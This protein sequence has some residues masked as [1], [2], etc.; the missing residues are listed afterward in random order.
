MKDQNTS[1]VGL[2][3]STSIQWDSTPALKQEGKEQAPC[4]PPTTSPPKLYCPSPCG[5][6]RYP[7]PKHPPPANWTQL[8]QTPKRKIFVY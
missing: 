8:R 1:G 5:W 4:A 2:G 6:Q 7:K 3:N